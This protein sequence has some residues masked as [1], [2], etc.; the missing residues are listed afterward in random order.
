M[1]DMHSASPPPQQ[2]SKRDKRRTLLSD[3]LAEM[4]DSFSQNRDQH[5]RAQLQAVQ[6]DMNL[7]MRADL[8]SDS[9]LEDGTEEIAEMINPVTEGN[10]SAGFSSHPDYMAQAGKAYTK[11]VDQVNNA[12]EARDAGIT[13]LWN[14]YHS[15]LQELHHSTAYKTRLAHEEHHALASTI[16]ERLVQSVNHKRARLLREKEQLDIGDSNTQLL[17]PNQFSIAHPASPGGA[18]SN[19][20]TRHLRHRVGDPDELGQETSKRRRKFGNEDNENDNASPGPTFRPLPVEVI[21]NPLRDAKAKT[22]HTQYEAP[23]YSVE[24]LFTEKELTMTMNTAHVATQNFFSRLKAQE[25]KNGPGQQQQAPVSTAPS[26]MDGATDGAIDTIVPSNAEATTD[27]H[28]AIEDPTQIAPLAPLEMERTTS[29]S[30]HVTRGS[31]RTLNA[32]GDLALAAERALPGVSFHA[33]L[34]PIVPVAKANASAPTPA[35]MTTS[36]VEQDV[37]LMGRGESSEEADHLMHER[38]LERACAPMGVSQPFRIPNLDVLPAAIGVVTMPPAIG[39]RAM[40]GVGPVGGVPMSAQ[41]SLGGMSEV[42][43]TRMR[44]DGAGGA[45]MMKRTASGAGLP[46]LA[47]KIRSRLNG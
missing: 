6:I 31:T 22:L 34:P 43:G 1:D 18:H 9:P 45:P 24:R 11:F 36:E 39:E 19:R 10:V 29:T 17:H 41:T 16:R 27:A 28:D 4:V 14:R 15:S 46:D 13:S 40:G 12:M 25:D 23:L 35:A 2:L 44:G 47:K 21:A 33:A 30:H 5:Y 3:R 26:A 42:A 8:Y 7:I 38:L 32:L 20:K 37:L